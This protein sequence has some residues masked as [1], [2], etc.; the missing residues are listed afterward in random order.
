MRALR[1]GDV[2]MPNSLASTSQA[3]AELCAVINA[4]K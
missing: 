1:A 4:K 3:K 2:F